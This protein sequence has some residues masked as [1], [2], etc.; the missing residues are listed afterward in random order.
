[1]VRHLERFGLLVSRLWSAKCAAKAGTAKS[2]TCPSW[3]L[4]C[5]FPR[6]IDGWE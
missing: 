3:A 4:A 5:V 1:M 2:R 6:G